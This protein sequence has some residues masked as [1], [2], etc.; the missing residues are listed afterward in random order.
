MSSSSSTQKQQ[1]HRINYSNIQQSR[2]TNAYF[3]RN[4]YY[5][6]SLITKNNYWNQ[7]FHESNNDFYM[8]DYYHQH[9]N[10]YS[11]SSRPIR[12]GKQIKNEQQHN[13]KTIFSSSSSNNNNNNHHSYYDNL[14][15]RHRLQQQQQQQIDKREQRS[16]RL[17]E[18][19]TNNKSDE[20]KLPNSSTKIEQTTKPLKS[21]SSSSTNSDLSNNPGSTHRKDLHAKNLAAA[22]IAARQHNSS[23]QT[24][25]STVQ[26]LMNSLI[27]QQQQQQQQPPSQ[28]QSTVQLQY[29]LTNAL[30]GIM[31]QQRLK[32]ATLQAQAQQIQATLPTLLAAQALVYQQQQQQQ[33]QLTGIQQQTQSIRSPNIAHPGTKFNNRPLVKFPVIRPTMS[34]LSSTMMMPI[35]R[36]AIT[37]NLSRHRLVTNS[38]Q[39][40][41][42]TT[43]PTYQQVQEIE[44][45]ISLDEAIH[46]K[47]AIDIA[48]INNNSVNVEAETI[49]IN[50]NI[51]E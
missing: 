16:S 19:R 20:I 17:Q 1:R 5:R 23:A 51:T 49:Q 37:T 46:L 43:L 4:D 31:I 7:N 22:A 26:A 32:E 35:I 50:N 40:C 6:Q 15:P 9:R 36:P 18:S 39:I 30:L 41:S 25:L 8:N 10:I 38:Q 11:L 42:T 34:P 44:R 3:D 2:N 47:G 13:S 45:G 48:N 33:G 29:Q 21:S 12:K 24:N 14:P 27:L 28:S